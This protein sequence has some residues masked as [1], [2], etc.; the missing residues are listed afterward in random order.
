MEAENVSIGWVVTSGEF[1]E[2]ALEYNKEIDHQ[3]DLVDGVQLATIIVEE[4]IRVFDEI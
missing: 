1:S 3:I 2:E 4:G